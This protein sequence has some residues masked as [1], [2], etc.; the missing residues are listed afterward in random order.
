MIVAVVVGGFRCE[1]W[2]VETDDCLKTLQYHSG[3]IKSV[4]FS[5]NGR[6]LAT[7]SVDGSV[8]LWNTTTGTCL[9]A[10][11]GHTSPVGAVT[12]SPDGCT[13]ATAAN[14]KFSVSIKIWNTNTGEWVRHMDLDVNSEVY[15]MLYTHGGRR[16][17]S[18]SLPSGIH[19]MCIIRV[20]ETSTGNC[21]QKKD[22]VDAGR[23]PFEHVDVW[24][25][26][27]MSSHYGGIV[28]YRTSEKNIEMWQMANNKRL[29]T[30]IHPYR[31]ARMSISS[32]RERLAVVSDQGTVRL[33]YL[34]NLRQQLLIPRDQLQMRGSLE[35][36]L[37][38]SGM[39]PVLSNALVLTAR[40]RMGSTQTAI[41][42]MQSSLSSL[43]SEHTYEARDTGLY[44]MFGYLITQRQVISKYYGMLSAP[45]RSV[46]LSVDGQ[47][48]IS[49][50]R[51]LLVINVWDTK[52]GQ[53]LHS[54][55]AETNEGER[56]LGDSPATAAFTREKKIL[57]A[58]TSGLNSIIIFEETAVSHLG[59]F[60]KPIR[61]RGIEM[62][63]DTI[64]MVF[65]GDA[66][67]LAVSY[68][69]ENH[70]E[71]G[72]EIWCLST[73]RCVGKFFIQQPAGL[74]Q[75]IVPQASFSTSPSQTVFAQWFSQSGSELHT[76]YGTINLMELAAEETGNS[77]AEVSRSTLRGYYI[78]G[79]WIMKDSC[80]II[81][82]PE[83]YRPQNGAY[84]VRGSML[85]IGCESGH[86]IIF[87]LS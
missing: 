35:T 54:F 36:K 3:E 48:A 85:A 45:I 84:V 55:H 63:R 50:R 30:T 6:T 87:Q 9:R 68:H 18:V 26:F 24:T 17:V 12:F 73:K 21:L 77:Y 43:K 74:F 46:N 71:I 51:G 42:P 14:S 66:A 67:R 1:L 79:E 75:R 49:V 7:G 10:L 22:V 80:R 40:S 60:S 70:A 5:H 13:I 76:S 78:E 25:P 58:T 57:L 33:E 81:W 37:S 59:K 44:T 4:A 32:D 19:A 47:K 15:S 41:D 8:T 62:R 34:T 29:G 31:C 72:V 61:A 16:I 27:S 86:V 11:I 2:S 23:K 28:A 65:S 53:C 52:S 20:L 39:E 83:E 56:G 69:L 64:G 82:L 38:V